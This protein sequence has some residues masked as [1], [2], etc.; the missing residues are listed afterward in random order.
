MFYDLFDAIAL[1]N[2]NQYLVEL[3]V[4]DDDD[5]IRLT[6]D[7]IRAQQA[8]LSILF[9]P[10]LFF[11]TISN[12]ANISN[13]SMSLGSTTAD[14][15]ACEVFQS[16]LPNIDLTSSLTIPFIASISAGCSQGVT[17][18]HLSKIW[19]IPF[20]DAVKTLA[21]TTQ[22][23]Q[24]NP[25]SLLSHNAGTNDRAVRFKTLRSKFFTD[26]MF[27]TKAAKSLRGNTCCQVFVLDKDFLAPYPMRQ[28][29]EYPLALKEFAK[30]VGAPD[31]LVCD[32][33]KTQ[34][35]QQVKVPR[36][37]QP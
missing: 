37:G 1:D 10:S 28:E 29:L 21:M 22:L 11:A 7:G 8:N 12:Q 4:Y 30:E 13:I 23:I 3:L 24:Q 33:S 31:A 9:E 6:Q 35:Q 25:G 14:D 15:S 16:K 34:N 5:E 2:D 27:A 19:R 18:E 17:P 26:T 20:D 32:G 36:W